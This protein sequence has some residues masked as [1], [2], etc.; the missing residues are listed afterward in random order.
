MS[1]T[2][3]NAYTQDESAQAIGRVL[4]LAGEKILNDAEVQ[5]FWEV[6]DEIQRRSAP[7]Q[8]SDIIHKYEGQDAHA[9]G[10]SRNQV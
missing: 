7:Y 3:L 5:R 8:R 2:G 6:H 1:V 9:I 10:L 4:A